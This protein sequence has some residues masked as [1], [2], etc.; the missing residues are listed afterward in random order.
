MVEQALKCPQCL[1]PL[2]APRRFERSVVCPF[3]GS[4]VLVDPDAVPAAK[5]RAAWRE[6]R[7]A[8]A[9]G[10]GGSFELGDG[11]WV[12]GGLVAHG[13]TC[14]VYAARR[15][16]WPSER[17]LLKV[18]REPHEAPRLD[19][20]WEVLT[21]L[22]ES[23]AAGAPVFTARLPRPVA[24]G[25]MGAWSEGS[26]GGSRGAAGGAGAAGTARAGGGGARAMALGWAD[27]FV[28]TFE[29][30]RRAHPPGIEPRASIWIWRRILEVLEFL[31][32]SGFVHGAVLPPHLLVEDGEHGVR[33]VGYGCA[34][35]TGRP[36]RMGRTGYTTVYP[37]AA[38]GGAPLTPAL[39]LAMSARCVAWLVGGDAGSGAVPAGVPRALAAEIGRVA[40]LD[41][42]APIDRDAAWTL[43][44]G[45][46]ELARQ[47]FGPPAF[48]PVTMP[49]ES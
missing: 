28:H 18:V 36:L 25:A 45:L 47:V 17:A 37:A 34:D 13:E 48:C 29:A 26:E 39:D 6:W 15:A 49:E 33:L 11:F 2:P 20:E 8:E 9:A 1:A 27:S 46:G 40:G 14:E 22:Q 23:E 19:H 5:F 38:R 21:R 30:V 31:H 41:L 10:A 24:H 12:R 35:R 44:Q 3:C 43:R 7:S 16:R 42:S 4:T 32:A